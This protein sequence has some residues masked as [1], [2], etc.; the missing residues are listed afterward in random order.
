MV[1]PVVNQNNPDLLREM[2]LGV[3]ENKRIQGLDEARI[4]CV[5]DLNVDGHG[6]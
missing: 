2:G 1:K 4:V 3:A 5:V 6:I